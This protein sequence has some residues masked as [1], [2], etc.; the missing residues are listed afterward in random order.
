LPRLNGIAGFEWGTGML[1]NTVA[2]EA[3]ADMLR[4]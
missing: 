4:A 2:P 3:A 1:I